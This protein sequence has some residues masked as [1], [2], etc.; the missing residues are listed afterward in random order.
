M[1]GPEPLYPQNASC[2]PDTSTKDEHQ[3]QGLK[4]AHTD[5]TSH[6]AGPGSSASAGQNSRLR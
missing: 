1:L 6:A 5:L 4:Q 2:R 3:P